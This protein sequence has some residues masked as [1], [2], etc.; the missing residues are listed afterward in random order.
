LRIANIRDF[1]HQGIFCHSCPYV[2][3]SFCKL[4]CKASFLICLH[5]WYTVTK[6]K[7]V[8]N[9][10]CRFNNTGKSCSCDDEVL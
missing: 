9:H 4:K 7:F 1:F 10:S 6:K 2:I 3:V 5:W 8:C